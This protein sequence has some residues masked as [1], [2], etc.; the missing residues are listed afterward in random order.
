MILTL[1]R[2]PDPERNRNPNPGLQRWAQAPDPRLDP[3]TIL[4]QRVP[5]LS[6][7][8]LLGHVFPAYPP[9]ALLRHVFPV[10]PLPRRCSATWRAISAWEISSLHGQA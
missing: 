3:A 2:V 7:Q 10:Y 6:P 9:P 4:R 8:A 1:Y 5:W